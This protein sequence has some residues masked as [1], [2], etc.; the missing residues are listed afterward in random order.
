V[1][2]G[3]GRAHRAS[4]PDLAN[5]ESL[6]LDILKNRGLAPQIV[7]PVANSSVWVVVV[8]MIMVMVMRLILELRISWH[9]KACGLAHDEPSAL[10]RISFLLTPQTRQ[11]RLS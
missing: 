1:P 9:K 10:G 7:H 4:L 8:M 11:R 2:D 6:P 3:G 5:D